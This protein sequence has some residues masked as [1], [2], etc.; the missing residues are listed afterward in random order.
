[1]SKHEGKI[2]KQEKETAMRFAKDWMAPLGKRGI[3][4]QMEKRARN[5]PLLLNA[6]ELEKYNQKMAPKRARRAKHREMKKFEAKMKLQNTSVE[7]AQV[8]A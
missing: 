7:S 8:G 4:K 5:A 3:V 1:M 6:E 2:E